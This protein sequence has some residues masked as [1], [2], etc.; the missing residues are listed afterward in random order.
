MGKGKAG[1]SLAGKGQS[2]PQTTD[3]L[4]LQTPD[5]TPDVPIVHSR[6]IVASSTVISTM[7]SATCCLKHC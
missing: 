4:T 5:V 1:L 7:L 2:P 6:I 3:Q